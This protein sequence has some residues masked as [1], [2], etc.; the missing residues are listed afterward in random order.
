MIEEYLTEKGLIQCPKCKEWFTPYPHTCSTQAD[1][2]WLNKHLC[3]LT[4]QQMLKE[5]LMW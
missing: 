4:C 1:K 2:K 3:P 5:G